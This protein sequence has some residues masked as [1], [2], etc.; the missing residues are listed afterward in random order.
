MRTLIYGAGLVCL[1]WNS[2]L[3]AGSIDII[4]LRNR[5]AEEMLPIIRPMLDSDGAISGSGFQ[6]I[7]RTSPGNLAQIKQIISKLDTAPRQLM[8]S[9][10]QGSQRDLEQASQSVQLHY[11]NNR[12]HADAGQPGSASAAGVQARAGGL[13]IGG[14]INRTRS[15]HSE[16][17][18]QQLRIQEGS[19]GYIETG[20]SIPFF[21]GRVYRQHGHTIIDAG[22]AYKDIQT[23]FY[24][25]PRLNDKQVILDISPY[26]ESLSKRGGAIIKTQAAST[27]VTGP[28][29][30]WLEIGGVENQSSTGNTGIGSHYNTREHS[31]SSLWIRADLVK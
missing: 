21:S 4:D 14:S 28:V 12:I 8:I 15:H 19:A 18:V 22:T 13:S 3:I 23:G 29:G 11:Q 30:Q 7:I 6:L 20:Q 27:T 9:V 1:L 24:V 17:P 31:S 25:Q 26:R 10:F 16:T 5:P 2:L